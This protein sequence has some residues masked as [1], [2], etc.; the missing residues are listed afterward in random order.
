M[1]LMGT[2]VSACCRTAAIC[3][4]EKRFFFMAPSGPLG[5]RLCRKIHSRFGPIF[6]EPLNAYLWVE[7]AD[8]LATEFRR[9]RV[10]FVVPVGDREYGCRDFTV[11][12]CNGY[13]LCFGH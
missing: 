6:P 7:D 12:D 11:D 8:V 1:S 9:K 10:K 4:V 13:R 3:S 2:P 5:A